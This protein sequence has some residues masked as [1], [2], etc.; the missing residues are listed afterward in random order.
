MPPRPQPLTLSTATRTGRLPTIRT[1]C[2]FPPSRPEA[3]H[4]CRWVSVSHWPAL[5]APWR[6]SCTR[7]SL[8]PA[9]PPLSCRGP[10]VPASTRTLALLGSLGNRSG[11]PLPHTLLGPLP[12]EAPPSDGWKSPSFLLFF[13][14]KSDSPG[15]W[16][17]GPAQGPKGGAC[18]WIRRSCSEP[19]EGRETGGWPPGAPGSLGTNQQN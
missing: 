2:P 5:H 14:R 12:P 8:H 1:S 4:E 18:V 11:P 7:L 9:Q 6:I 17:P 3:P 10:K 13:F 19:A 16:G 15:R